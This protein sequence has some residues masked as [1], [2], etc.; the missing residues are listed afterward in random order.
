M[1]ET[2][3]GG[4]GRIVRAILL[5]LLAIMLAAGIAG[6]LMAHAEDGGGTIST[7]GLAILAG[8]ALALAATIFVIF[9]DVRV[10]VGGIDALPRRERA[11]V[12]LLALSVAAGGIVG[13]AV[14][15]T[16]TGSDWVFGPRGVIAPIPAILV[17]LLLLTLGPWM[18]WR[19]W[20]QID[21][22]EQSAYVD[23]AN[24]AGHFALFGG[25][26]WWILDRA[27]LVPAPN[28]M[29][30]VIA[31]SCVWTGVWFYRKFY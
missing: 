12:R 27:A 8:F 21:E 25:I 30:L 7:T 15:I 18:S 22:H 23:G 16:A 19:W 11:T 5:S 17:T 1:N 13:S 9:R 28:I 26:G 29:V 3:N 24:I 14:A 10:L 31:M 4:W 20:R 2:A 6:F